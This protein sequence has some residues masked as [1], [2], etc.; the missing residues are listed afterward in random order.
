MRF[1]TVWRAFF[2]S[3][4]MAFAAPFRPLLWFSLGLCVALMVMAYG[5]VLWLIAGNSNSGDITEILGPVRGLSDLLSPESALFMLIISTIFM[6]PVA[7]AVTSVIID[8]VGDRLTALRMQPNHAQRRA[9]IRTPLIDT[10]NFLGLLLAANVLVIPVYPFVGP[11]G[12]LVFWGLNGL[13]LG[14]EYFLLTALRHHD[15]KAA[16]TLR[17][18]HFTTTWMAGT[19][20]AMGLSIPFFNFF[21]PLLGALSFAYLFEDLKAAD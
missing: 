17:R 1:K 18:R 9:V 12:L 5:L 13:M 20:M 3:L 2:R 6:A 11:L 15:L 14:R 21:V 10:L 19:L 7:S 8:P 4:G 16:R